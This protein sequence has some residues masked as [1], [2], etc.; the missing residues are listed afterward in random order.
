MRSVRI[1]GSR[2]KRENS[3]MRSFRSRTDPRIMSIAPGKISAKRLLS[4]DHAERQRLGGE[5]HGRE[6]VLD[7]VDHPLDGLLPRLEPL[8]GED[9]REVLDHHDG[10]DGP[11]T[12]A[13]ERG[14]DHRERAA[15]VRQLADEL[16]LA[17]GARTRRAPARP[18]RGAAAPRRAP[19]R[20]GGRSALSGARPRISPARSFHVSMRP[21]SSSDTT[22]VPTFAMTVERWFLS[23]SSVACD[24]RS[25][26]VRASTIASR[27]RL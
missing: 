1:S 2:E 23:A 18:P 19:P 10:A 5:P 15:A 6:R 16:R 14:G 9:L 22:P 20:P 11:A 12:L 25:S 26:D 13:E 21:S 7:L 17:S 27:L 3:P 8:G 4:R 24:A